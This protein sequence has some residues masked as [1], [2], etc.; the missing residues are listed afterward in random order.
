MNILN[1]IKNNAIL[2]GEFPIAGSIFAGIII[3]ICLLGIVV[4]QA[5]IADFDNM[6][7]ASYVAK[8]TNVSEKAVKI[9]KVII[10]AYSSTPDQTDDTPNITASNKQVRD[11]IIANNM[12]PFGTKVRIPELYGDKIFVVEDRMNRR[13]SNYHIDI[14][15]PDRESAI[16]FG[17]KTAEIEILES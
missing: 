10:T 17:V 7:N 4:P 3:G 1:I 13:K 11:G 5:T 12:L 16:I 15:M 2:K 6:T 9:I 8:N 14:W